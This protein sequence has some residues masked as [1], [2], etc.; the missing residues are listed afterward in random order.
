MI[1]RVID[2]VAAT[3]GLTQVMV[4]TDDARVHEAMAKHAARRRAG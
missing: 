3:P 2:R 1:A 4:A